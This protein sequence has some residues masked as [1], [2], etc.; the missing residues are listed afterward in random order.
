MAPDRRMRTVY[1]L[2][3]AMFLTAI[4]ATVVDTAMPRIVGSL[5]GF[6]MLTWLVTAYLLT[7][8]STVPVYGKLADLFGRRRTFAVGA[9]LFLAGSALCGLARS[10]PQLVAFRALQGLGA[11]AVQPVVQTIIGD[12][13][14]PQERARYQAWFSAVWGISALVGPLVGGLVVDHV[15]WRW[16]FYINLPLGGLAIYMVLTQ[17]EER[18][19]RRAATI[20]YLG[21]ALL[22]IGT[23]AVLLA[24]LEGGVTLPWGSAPVLALLGGGAALLA[25]FVLQERRHPDPMLP[26][27]LFRTPTIGLA[28]LATF[29]IGG[30]FYG[31]TVF[32]PLWA[33]GVQGYSATRSGASL[34][35]LSVGWPLASI[36]ASRYILRV[37]Q[38][39]AAALG[40]VLQTAA[41]VGLLVLARLHRE[42]PELAFAGVTF[43][44]GAG[45]GLATLSFILGVQSAVGWERRGVATASLQFVRTLGGLV[46]VALMGAA[47]NRTLAAHLRALPEV[48][49]RT[50][51]QAAAF[52]SDLLDP[53]QR[54]VLS[55]ATVEAAREA[56]AQALRGVHELMV[57]CAA[58]ALAITLLL[59]DVRL[60]ERAS[61]PGARAG[62]AAVQGPG[63][64]AGV[65]EPAS[66]SARSSE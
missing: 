38:R 28:N 40:L 10:M 22:T 50:S 34:L 43:V 54:A 9:T 64:G 56:L 15:S 51:A 27:D 25:L 58:V 26:L 35:W 11:G 37:G 44:I 17:L 53:V 1:A 32:L 63:S 12:L 16:L 45:M 3:L 49:V 18:A 23:S 39:R 31:T 6:S 2:M 55:P 20:D 65:P 13:F 59:P 60:G 5:G 57:V 19:P 33:Q 48:S 24:L 41:S 36:F 46:W 8:T 66:E 4:D 7:S 47:V 14:S 21:S 61:A 30:V 52:A 29:M 62:A 42:L